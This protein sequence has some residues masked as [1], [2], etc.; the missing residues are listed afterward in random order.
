MATSR[1]S[2]TSEKVTQ[3]PAA[4]VVSRE[5]P[6]R[7]S[8]PVEVLRKRLGNAGLARALRSLHG[9]T[10]GARVQRADSEA[11]SSGPDEGLEATFDRVMQG[12]VEEKTIQR[13]VQVPS[14]T[15]LPSFHKHLTKSGDIYSYDPVD[16][17]KGKLTFEIFTALLNSPRVFKLQ[18]DSSES[19]ESALMR[20]IAARTGVVDFANTNKYTFTGARSNFKMNPKYWWVDKTQGTFGIKEG[21]DSQTARDDLN[22]HPEEYRIGCAAATKITVQGGGESLQV[23]G[24]TAVD[25]DWVPGESGYIKNEGWDGVA[26]GLEGEN[27]I[28]MGGKEYWGHFGSEQSVKPYA[29]WF[30]MVDGW[31]SAAKLQPDRNWPSK[32]LK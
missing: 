25:Q 23:E 9:T 14:G 11:E 16:R 22:A 8:R 15:E 32:G 4:P 12:R 21:V 5:A 18:G 26:A 2:S 6:R 20:H 7:G 17:T 27:I 3:R 10:A 30:E 24:T 13:K 28:Y 19:A 1:S 31:N 29:K